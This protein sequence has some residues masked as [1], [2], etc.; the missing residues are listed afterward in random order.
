[1]SAATIVT[2]VIKSTPYLTR[3]GLSLFWIYLTLGSRVR[4]TRRAF[5]EQ[6]TAQG[7]SKEDAQRLSACFQDLKDDLTI[8]L[9][10]G[11]MSGLRMMESR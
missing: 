5:E 3:I 2:T 8:T 11:M 7:M 10:Q 6:L 4:A 1:M 9:K